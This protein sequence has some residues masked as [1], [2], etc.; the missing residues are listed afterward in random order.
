MIAKARQ[1]ISSTICGKIEKTLQAQING[2]FQQMPRSISVHDILQ[3]F[4]NEARNRPE[5]ATVQVVK[6]EHFNLHVI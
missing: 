4:T 5:I 2:R 6:D 3:Y 1:I